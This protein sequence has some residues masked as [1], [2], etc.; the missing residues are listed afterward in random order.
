MVSVPFSLPPGWL[1]MAASYNVFRIGEIFQAVF[2]KNIAYD[3][4]S[5]NGSPC[6]GPSY[7]W[8]NHGESTSAAQLKTQS[9]GGGAEKWGG[10]HREG[11]PFFRIARPRRFLYEVSL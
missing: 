11:R 4:M 2:T 10:S 6:W 5:L 1:D 8:E 7:P 3:N 9:T